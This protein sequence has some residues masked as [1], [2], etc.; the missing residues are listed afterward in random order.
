[1]AYRFSII[2]DQE[3]EMGVKSVGIPRSL[4]GFAESDI[5]LFTPESVSVAMEMVMHA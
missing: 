3:Q 1:M 2:V 5:P 4:H